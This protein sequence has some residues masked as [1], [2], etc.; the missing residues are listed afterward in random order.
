MV[1]HARPPNIAYDKRKGYR[2]GNH[3]TEYV[4]V[5]LPPKKRS[6]QFIPIHSYI[7][8]QLRNVSHYNMIVRFC[9]P[10]YIVLGLPKFHHYYPNPIITHVHGPPHTHIGSGRYVVFSKTLLSL[11]MEDSQQ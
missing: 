8:M 3:S 9:S 2:C 5:P 1:K 4:T 7:I 6:K 11:T 10:A